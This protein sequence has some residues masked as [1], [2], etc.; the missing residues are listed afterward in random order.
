MEELINFNLEY[1]K[2]MTN[3]S[4]WFSVLDDKKACTAH[5]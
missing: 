5:F 1:Y 4:K 2:V 3:S